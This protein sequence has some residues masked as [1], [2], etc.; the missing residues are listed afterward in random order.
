MQI[1]QQ[2]YGVAMPLIVTGLV[3]ILI[4]MVTP[5]GDMAIKYFMEKIEASGVTKKLAQHQDELLTAKSIWNVVEE[6]YRITEKAE[7]LLV[8][9]AD[10]FDELLLQKVPYLTK[11]QLAELRQALAGE[12]NKGKQAVLNDD[13]LKQ[14]TVDLQNQNSQ[15]VAQN[16]EVSAQNQVL[17]SQVQ[18]LNNK[19]SAINSAISSVSQPQPVQQ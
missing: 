15:L 2:I 5:V 9:K 17:Q 14:K 3:G 16:N 11:E 6:K 10:M 4:K 19:L 13:S 7:D 12:F 1:L 8:S 18:E